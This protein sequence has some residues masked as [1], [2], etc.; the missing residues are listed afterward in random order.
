MTAKIEFLSQYYLFWADHVK[1][2]KYQ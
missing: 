1:L 2:V